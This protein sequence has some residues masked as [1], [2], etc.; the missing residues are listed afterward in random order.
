M[1]YKDDKAVN[2]RCPEC[3][4]PMREETHRCINQFSGGVH[5]A[6][7]VQCTKCPERRD[8]SW[9]KIKGRTQK[10]NDN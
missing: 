6:L 1:E 9:N 2:Y 5:Y 7:L 10:I 3:G 4:A 8:M